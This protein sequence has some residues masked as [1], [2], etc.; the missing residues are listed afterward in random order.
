MIRSFL[1]ARR[2]RRAFTLIELLVVIAIIAILAAMLL[3]A[4]AKARMKAATVSC[5][6]NMKQQATGVGLYLTDGKEELP[7]AMLRWRANAAYTWDDLLHS[8]MGGPEA[9]GQLRSWEPQNAQGGR[10]DIADPNF[11]NNPPAMKSMKCPADRLFCG[12]TRFPDARRSYAM[13]RHS[14]DQANGAWFNATIW[15]PA[16]DN[17]TGV[18]LVWPDGANQP[19]PAR[20]WFVN[21]P[22]GGS[23]GPDPRYI[24]AVSAGLIKSP[25]QVIFNT[26]QP[27]GTRAAN[28]TG[29]QSQQGSVGM[30]SINNANDHFI[31]NQANQN[32]VDTRTYHNSLVNYMFV[33]GHAE[34]LAPA[35]TLGR[36]N[37]VLSRQTGFWTIN[38]GD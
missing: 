27:R 36:T 37:T 14:T 8:Y 24:P 3:P 18:G 20:A 16:G 11:R 34:N 30:Q 29:T 28:I 13:S 12:D 38:P 17:M 4:L 15:P 35:A 7:Y 22:W 1:P 26:E 31:S 21:D 5:L 2:E 6:N 19:K 9:F 10:A 25:D 32:Y 33:D 23:S